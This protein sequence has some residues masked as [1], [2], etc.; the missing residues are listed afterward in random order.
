VHWTHPDA[1]DYRGLYKVLVLPPTDLRH[2]VLPVKFDDRLL[3]PLCR[4]CAIDYE[5]KSTRV[6]GYRCPTLM[7]NALLHAP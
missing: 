7:S 6:N 5:K 4:T 3:F 1:L 2:P